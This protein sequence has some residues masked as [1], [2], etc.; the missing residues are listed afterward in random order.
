[1]N[2]KNDLKEALKYLFENKHG[3][4]KDFIEKFN[5]EMFLSMTYMNFLKQCVRGNGDKSW[6]VTNDLYD[7]YIIINPKKEFKTFFDRIHDFF[8]YIL[9]TKWENKKYM[10]NKNKKED[11]FS[12]KN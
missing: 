2:K 10:F 7:F 6:E 12:F 4:E 8:D 5:K 3:L 1:M 11:Y 9:F